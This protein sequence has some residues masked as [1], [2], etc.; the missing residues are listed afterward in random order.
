MPA[1]AAAARTRASSRRCGSPRIGFARARRWGCGMTDK[2]REA[3][4]VAVEPERYEFVEGRRYAFDVDRR[5]FI[6]IFGAGLVVFVAAGDALAQES[7][8]AVRGQQ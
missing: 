6:R 2:A 1:C 5:D 8:R 4:A 3:I 7:G